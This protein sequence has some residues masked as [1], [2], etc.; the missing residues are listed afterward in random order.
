MW[1]ALGSSPAAFQI[2]ATITLMSASIS[3]SRIKLCAVAVSAIARPT[4][5]A[6]A[7]RS[8][9]RKVTE[10]AFDNPMETASNIPATGGERDRLFA[11][12]GR[13]A[14]EAGQGI[15]VPQPGRAAPRQRAHA[16]VSS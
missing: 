7:V 6:A 1:S 3:V 4:A 14:A 11:L 8:T 10:A 2:G 5:R 16:P 13:I 12:K 9:D 15:A